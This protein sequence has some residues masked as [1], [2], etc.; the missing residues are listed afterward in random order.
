MRGKKNDAFLRMSE[1]DLCNA[2]PDSEELYRFPATLRAGATWQGLEITSVARPS[3]TYDTLPC[4]T[5]LPALAR[6]EAQATR[7]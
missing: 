7:R 4:L 1:E 3:C 2:V 5:L 6:F